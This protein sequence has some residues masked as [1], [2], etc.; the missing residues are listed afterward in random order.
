MCKYLVMQVS[1]GNFPTLSFHTSVD[2]ATKAFLNYALQLG[3]WVQSV[4]VYEVSD[5][6]SHRH[7]SAVFYS[8]GEYYTIPTNRHVWRP[9]QR[10]EVTLEMMDEDGEQ[11]FHEFLVEGIAS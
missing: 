11:S 7:L 1:D 5:D 3:K 4:H 6:N 8:D 2:E 9:A 10:D